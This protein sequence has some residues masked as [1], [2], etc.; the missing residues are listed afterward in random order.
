MFDPATMS[1]A[2]TS[3]KALLDLARGAND[4][5]LAMRISTEVANL[6]GKLIE[7]QQQALELQAEN[8]RLR[9]EIASFNDDREF[10]A[11][12]VFH[13]DGSYRREGPQ[14]EERYCSAC[15][16]DDGKRIRLV[17]ATC[18]VHGFRR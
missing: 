6:Q 3:I 16:D 1:A 8:Q 10:R 14:G 4:A 11:T 12:L 18:H 13:L 7:V 2:L 15:L 5:Q 9:A 17:G